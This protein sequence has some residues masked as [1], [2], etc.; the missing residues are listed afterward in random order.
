MKVELNSQDD[1]IV[2]LRGETEKEKKLLEEW[3]EDGVRIFATGSVTG[4]ICNKYV[5]KVPAPKI[6]KTREEWE[7]LNRN[8]WRVMEKMSNG[9]QNL[10]RLDEIHREL[11][12]EHEKIK[13]ILKQFDAIS[14]VEKDKK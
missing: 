2:Y 5:D 9:D 4:M 12:D 3:G 8:V 7:Q 6:P 13:A 10:K 11:R 1:K 14:T